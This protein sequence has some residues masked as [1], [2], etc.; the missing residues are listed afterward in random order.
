V[1]FVI[2]LIV[3][4]SPAEACRTHDCTPVARL[5]RIGGIDRA[6]LVTIDGAYR[7]F[8]GTGDHWFQLPDETLRQDEVGCGAGSCGEEHV[9][10]VR[11]GTGP[12]DAVQVIAELGR[13]KCVNGLNMLDVE[14][15]TKAY[16]A[17]AQA[18]DICH[19]SWR[20][21]TFTLSCHASEGD[22]PACEGTGTAEANELETSPPPTNVC[23]SAHRCVRVEQVAAAPL[24]RVDLR[25]MDGYYRLFVRYS[26]QWFALPAGIEAY[27]ESSGAGSVIVTGVTA[28]ELRPRHDGVVL[29]TTWAR[30]AKVRN[31]ALVDGSR[32]RQRWQREVLARSALTSWTYETRCFLET[33]RR[34]NGN[35]ALYD[36]SYWRAAPVCL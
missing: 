7:L 30:S 27:S 5:D 8:V 15:G 6:E 19:R 31:P 3:S 36:P 14:R 33:V 35:E 32:D 20:R 21:S 23:R 4:A 9:L 29:R 26:G 18:L 22:A 12:D 16:A 1:F 17:A 2:I 13:T 11:L 34:G 24:E 25:L 10:S 28:I